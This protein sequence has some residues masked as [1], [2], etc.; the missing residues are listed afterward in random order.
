[1]LAQNRILDGVSARRKEKSSNWEEPSS[2]SVQQAIEDTS[3]FP[4]STHDLAAEKGGNASPAITLHAICL[5]SQLTILRGKC[6][7]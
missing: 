6:L 1:M 5:P 3:T 4:S 7:F 2:C